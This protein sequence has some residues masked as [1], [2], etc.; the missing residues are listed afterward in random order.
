MIVNIFLGVVYC[1]TLQINY[2]FFFDF[3]TV[4]CVVTNLSVHL[5]R[6][7]SSLFRKH[8]TP[9]LNYALKFTSNSHPPLYFKRCSYDT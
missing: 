8:F 5:Q 9:R 3:T 2:R 4:T 7:V 1:S 6:L